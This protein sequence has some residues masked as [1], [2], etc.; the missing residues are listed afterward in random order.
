MVEQIASW[1]TQARSGRRDIIVGA[2]LTAGLEA[3]RV[4][5]SESASVDTPHRY[6]WRESW[7]RV[8]DFTARKLG[9]AK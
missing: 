9:S 6:Q 8:H 2:F 7:D 1:E 3:S 5:E 4:G